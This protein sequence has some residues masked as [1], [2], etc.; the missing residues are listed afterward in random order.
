MFTE[1]INGVSETPCSD[2]QIAI[3][4]VN[5]YHLYLDK[6]GGHYKIKPYLMLFFQLTQLIF[7]SN[8]RHQAQV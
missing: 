6:K 2:L 5:L 8:S 1:V 7:F 3:I 4:L